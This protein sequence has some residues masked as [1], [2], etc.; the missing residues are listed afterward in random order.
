M[1]PLP[2]PLLALLAA[3]PALAELI[4]S[5]PLAPDVAALPRVAGDGAVPQAVN[6]ALERRDAKDLDAVNCFG[7]TRSDGPFRSVEILSDGPDFLS[8]FITIGASCEGAA[9]PWSTTTTL[10]IDLETGR[11][12]DLREFLPFPGDDPDASLAVLFLNAV[13][14]LPGECLDAYAQAFREGWLGFDLGL[15]EARGAL[16]VWPKGL[17]YPQTP[18]LDVAYVP[19][20]RLREAGFDGRL[21]DALAPAD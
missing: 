21:T 12:T 19:V 16:V 9:H 4:P 20:A 8:F 6:V 18:C 1:R 15:A 14:D 17:A 3:G 13:D 7:G 2:L 5:P 10:N 11:Q